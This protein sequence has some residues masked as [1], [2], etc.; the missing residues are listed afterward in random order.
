MLGMAGVTAIDTRV[1]ALTLS[2]VEPVMLP[3]VAEI[4]V[5]PTLPALA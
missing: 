3:S 1:A 4:V 2:V 5:V